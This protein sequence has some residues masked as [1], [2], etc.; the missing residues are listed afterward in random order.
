MH[1]RSYAM[2]S[3]VVFALIAVAQTLRAAQALPIQVGPFNIP[4][5]ASWIAAAVA[6]T[7]SVWAFRTA[8]SR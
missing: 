2:T 8:R 5:W 7:L 3:G 6:G 1:A 4:V